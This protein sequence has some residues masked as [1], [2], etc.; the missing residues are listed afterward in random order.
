MTP[1]ERRKKKK[2]TWEQRQEQGIIAPNVA[3]HEV[4]VAEML[5]RRRFLVRE[6]MF[7]RHAQ[8]AALERFIAEEARN[9][10]L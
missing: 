9:S 3:I 5:V 2:K 7:N 10:K 6:D 8:V 1:R 4:P